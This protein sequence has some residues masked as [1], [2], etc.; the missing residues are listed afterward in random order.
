MKKFIIIIIL[1]LL[2]GVTMS[3][4]AQNSRPIEV[5]EN[6]ELLFSFSEDSIILNG[7]IP[8]R[9][10]HINYYSHQMDDATGVH[11]FVAAYQLPLGEGCSRFDIQFSLWITE[12][13]E[14][15]Y[16][17]TDFCV[18][19]AL[20]KGQDSLAEFFQPQNIIQLQRDINHG[21]KT[22]N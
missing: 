6:G 7:A 9:M 11:Y 15:Y 16:T 2:L 4:S 20:W 19:F 5:H 17:Y 18:G 21:V 12:D 3:L 22:G 1:S 8:L 13:L 10:D 14:Y